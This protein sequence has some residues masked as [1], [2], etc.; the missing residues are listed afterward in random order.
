MKHGNRIESSRKPC[1]TTCETKQN[2]TKQNK[3]VKHK[4]I[5]RTPRSHREESGGGS[6]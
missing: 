5:T 4:Y 1:L 6:T 3:T 2:K